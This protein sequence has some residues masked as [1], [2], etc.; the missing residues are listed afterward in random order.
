MRH[1]QHALAAV[2]AR[3]HFQQAAQTQNHVAPALAAWRTKV[4]LADMAA[5]LMQI[6]VLVLNAERRQA[7]KNA[8]LFFAQTLVHAQL[9]SAFDASA[10]HNQ[11]SRFHGP[12]VGRTQQYLRLLRR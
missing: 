9:D 11:L 12:D 10:V 5:L 7:V 2:L 6:R 4:K 1:N 3:H 8:K